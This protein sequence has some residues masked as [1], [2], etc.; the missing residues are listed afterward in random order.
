MTGLVDTVRA[1][2][3]DTCVAAGGLRKEG[4][5]VSLRGAPRPRLIVDFDKPGS[6]LTRTETR[7]DYLLVAEVKN[8]PGWVT[9]LELKKGRLDAGKAVSQLKAGSRAAE[10]LVPRTMEVNFRPAVASGG[11]KSEREKLRDKKNRVKFHEAVEYVRLIS[12]GD[13][14]TKALDT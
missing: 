11:N 7:C 2:V 14:L 8:Q 5:S 9:L 4:C 6:P 10:E 3:E 12:C 13:P 1:R